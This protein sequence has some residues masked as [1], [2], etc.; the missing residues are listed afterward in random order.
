MVSLWN[1]VKTALLLGG[2]VALFVAIGGMLGQEYLLPFLMI[3]LV[4]NVGAFLFSDRIAITAMRGQEVGEDNELYR[5]VDRL[6]Q[7]AGLP[8]PRVYVCP[9]DAPNAFATGRSPSRS[10][11]A[12]TRGALQ[13]LDRDE[14]EGVLAHELAHIKNRDTLIS[15]IAATIAGVLAFLAQWGF[16]FLGGSREGGNPLVFFV[17]IIVGAIGAAL[18]KMAV[19]RSR[20]YVADA[21]GARIAGSPRGLMSALQKLEAVSQR[22][23]L[24]NPNPAANNLFIVEPLTGGGRTLANL[25]ATHPPMEKRIE[26]LSRV[27]I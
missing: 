1:N 3:G 27:S 8:M 22:V 24:Q 15:T 4:M 9:H 20:E 16:F 7:R 5:M 19:S 17:V 21:D 23:P 25:F 18:L 10:A 12:V 26:A 6:R 2:M 13:L 11:V 14:L